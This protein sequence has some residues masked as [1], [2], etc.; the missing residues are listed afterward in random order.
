MAPPA[1]PV[2]EGAEASGLQAYL[3]DFR[4]TALRLNRLADVPPETLAAQTSAPSPGRRPLRLRRTGRPNGAAGYA[5]VLA[6]RAFT[7]NE[8]RASGRQPAIRLK[9]RR[10]D[11]GGWPNVAQNRR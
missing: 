10:R 9:T 11:D 6:V 4:P 8:D 5:P 1:C 3:R 2:D 7:E